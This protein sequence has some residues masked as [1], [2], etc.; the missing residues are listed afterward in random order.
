MQARDSI[1]YR[2]KYKTKEFN[3]A[4]I[5]DLFKIGDHLVHDQYGKFKNASNIMKRIHIP[6]IMNF[7][8]NQSSSSSEQIRKIL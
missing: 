4:L 2:I 1:L 3:P 5:P 6:K 8:L 7:N